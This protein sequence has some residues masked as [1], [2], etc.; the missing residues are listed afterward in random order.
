VKA[1]IIAIGTELLLGE[2]V[3]TN[4]SYLAKE[5]AALGI[6]LYYMTTVGDNE[7]RIAEAIRQALARADVVITTGGLGPTVDDV[8]REA[9][10]RAT[11]REL[12]LNQDCLQD[13]ELLFSRWGRPMSEN[14]RRQAYLPQGSIPIPNPVGT[15]PAFIVEIE[16]PAGQTS[17]AVISLPGVPSE[18]KHLWRTRIFPY[19]QTRLGEAGAV[20]K[21]KTLRTCGIGESA[22]DACLDEL[23]RSSNPTVGLAAHPG[24][25]D[26]RITAKAA[27]ST[28][29]DRLIAEMEAQVRARVGEFIYGEGRET[30]EEVVARELRAA[31]VT[32]TILETN[33][34]GEVARR[35]SATPDGAYVLIKHLVVTETSSL[36]AILQLPHEW[37]AGRLWLDV[38][39]ARSLAPMMR[40]HAQA[41]LA[42]V[43]LGSTDV[44]EGL[45]EARTGLTF[46]ALDDGHHVITRTLPYG[47]T[48]S[49]ACR[50]IGNYAL[51]LVRRW[52]LWPEA[53]GVTL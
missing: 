37:P 18:M 20:I 12:Y 21:S 17:G 32:L 31:G 24:Q 15:A 10:A 7:I 29:A 39:T 36:S 23:L 5:L 8:T 45:Y 9:V 4:S 2:I 40:Q 44:S 42:L 38:D 43:I 48:S 41:D 13:I 34:G 28:E 14:N 47:G 33:T 30:L 27:T 11:G 26:I 19:L 35:L 1:E 49:L 22:V 53:K 51:D 16:G 52:L 46:L 25:T 3:D 6:D 50:W